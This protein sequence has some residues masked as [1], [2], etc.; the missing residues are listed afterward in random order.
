MLKLKMKKVLLLI[1]SVVS[2][3]ALG[4]N[5]YSVMQNSVGGG[6]KCVQS[7][8]SVGQA[9]VRYDAPPI[10]DK[11]YFCG[12]AVD[13]SNYYLR[14]RF[15]RELLSFS[16]WHSQVF[17]IIKRANR[18]FPVIEPILEREGVPDDMKYLAVIESNLDQR[19]VSP[20]KAAGMWQIMPE[21]AKEHGLIVEDDVDERYNLEKATVA[22]CDYL[23][24]TYAL[25]NDWAAAAASYNTGRARV[26]RQME[27]Q[28]TNCYYDMLFSEE[29]NR[30]V[31]RIILAK[32]V[33]ENPRAFGFY[34]N[35]EDLYYPVECNTIM[36][37]STINNL[38]DFAK[39]YGISYQLLKDSNPWLRSNKLLNK[40][41]D[42]FYVKM[43]KKEALKVNPA[44]INV[45][46]EKW[47]K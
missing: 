24:K 18:Y 23:K 21:T 38:T 2:V 27:A 47:V 29:T 35:K 10:P 1:V 41:N 4:F 31:F 6:E 37:D 5:G 39:G 15:D 25:T 43:P 7:N 17:L 36:V 28:Q 13:L 26:V 40:K 9:S 30:Y 22:A 34:L 45:H 14:E 16:Y 46:Y 20:A 12:E 19:S 8:V 11:V 33:L 44:D 32:Y 3:G 42:T